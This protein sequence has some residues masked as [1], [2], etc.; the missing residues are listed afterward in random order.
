[1]NEQLNKVGHAGVGMVWERPGRLR[2]DNSNK[3]ARREWR[4]SEQ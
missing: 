3:E 2:S 4:A 1:M